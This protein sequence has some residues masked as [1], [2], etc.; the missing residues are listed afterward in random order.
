MQECQCLR[1]ESVLKCDCFGGSTKWDNGSAIE[2]NS[3]PGFPM[4]FCIK[5]KNEESAYI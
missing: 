3:L 2:E 5:Y 1:Q 4:K